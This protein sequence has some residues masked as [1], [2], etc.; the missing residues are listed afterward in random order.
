MGVSFDRLELGST[1]ALDCRTGQNKG[2]YCKKW[3]L[4]PTCLVGPIQYFESE[5]KFQN[6]QANFEIDHENLN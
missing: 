2:R 6:N 1:A 5:N 4:I 3:A